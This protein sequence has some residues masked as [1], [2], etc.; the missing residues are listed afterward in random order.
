MERPG[1]KDI[2][3]DLFLDYASN[4]KRYPDA[5]HRNDW[6]RGIEESQAGAKVRPPPSPTKPQNLMNP[7]APCPPN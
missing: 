4:L 7:T 1:N 6:R 3:L 5:D 2:Q